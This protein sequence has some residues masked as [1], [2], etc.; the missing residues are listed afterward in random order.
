MTYDSD[1]VV[2]GR[3]RRAHATRG[4]ISV[5]PVTDFPQ[6]FDGLRDVL[7]GAPDEEPR[8]FEIESVRWNGKMALVKLAGVDDRDGAAELGGSLMGVRR[9]QVAPTGEDEYYHFDLI[10]LKVVDE[11]GNEVGIVRDVLRMPANDVLVVKGGDRE[12]LVPTV[13]QV[14]KD[15]SL[16]E[17]V[18]TIERIPGLLD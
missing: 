7:I 16:D 14:I 13:K 5:E 4:E 8:E 11:K 3:I 1:F 9:S 6:R 12:M 17:R 2:I 15:V 18:I 10:G